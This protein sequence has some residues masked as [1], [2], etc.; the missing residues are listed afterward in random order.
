MKE[1]CPDGNIMMATNKGLLKYD[2]DKGVVKKYTVLDGLAD[3]D[4]RTLVR[5]RNGG[6][7][8]GTLNGLSFLPKDKE[9]IQSYSASL[10]LTEKSYV[11]SCPIRN[12]GTL[13]MGGFEGLTFFNSDSIS[14][15][16]F[17][18]NLKISGMYIN[19]KRITAATVGDKSVP[20]IEGDEIF[21]KA[22]HLSWKDRSLA[23]RL[24]TLDFRNTSR[25]RYEWQL[26]GDG[27]VWNSTA[28]GDNFVYLPSLDPGNYVLRLRGWEDNVCSDVSELMLNI[29]KPWYQ[30][31]T[32]KV[33]YVLIGLF[34]LGLLYKVIKSKREEELNEAKIKFFMDISHE[35]RSPITL[36]LSPVDSLLKQPQT[37]Q[38]TA[39]LLTVRRNAQRVLNLADQMLDIRKIEKGK[40]RLV[41][42]PTDLCGFI[43]ELVEMFRPQA[44]DK[45]LKIEFRSSEQSLMAPV[46]RNNLDK[47]LVNLISNAVKYTPSGGEIV[48]DLSR[49]VD[50]SERECY[51]IKVIDTGIGLDNKLI[52]H[53]FER[54]YRGREHHQQNT[55]GFG[56]GLDLCTRLVELHGGEI[57]G[58]NR[59]DGVKG[60]VFT[61]ILPI[62]PA[63]S[64][65]KQAPN[66]IDTPASEGG[67]SRLPFFNPAMPVK[68]HEASKSGRSSTRY[69]VMVVDDDTELRE[70]IKANLGN[71][72]KV[73]TFSSGE[74]AMKELA[75]KVPDII[76]TDIRMDGMDGFELLKRV[77]GNIST[78]HVPVILF[79]SINE[80]TERT[81]GWKSG[82][83]G[84]IAKPFSI[85]ELAGMING[86]L[87]TRQKLKGKFSGNQDTHE[88]IVMPKVKGMNQELMNSVDRYITENLSETELNV[89]NLSEYVGLSRSQLNR[90]L[91]EIVGISPSDYIRNI[92]LQKACELLRTTDIDISQV[93]Y[94]LGF[95]AQSHFSTLFKRFTGMTPSEYRANEK[96]EGNQD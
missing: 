87:S 92:K 34:I 47:I 59:E 51:E 95:T 26:S 89:D 76:V 9:S 48:V 11:F 96:R 82:A 37:P 24:S 83:D 10:G 23:L 4:V 46:D 18:G 19:G 2:T 70:Y 8:I 31:D 50:S 93:A 78:H 25:V 69:N 84:Y 1:P 77:K 72:Y 21:P 75:D 38:T 94:A 62:L 6:L 39:Q 7:W 65:T 36:L 35:I 85:D 53:L 52:K 68:P 17:G 27:D 30:A 33:V 66:I 90:R 58:K 15:M 61:V 3:N 86:L 20:I 79:S 22:L 81:R 43:R 67:L 73:K 12:Q 55:P 64:D 74:E 71:G 41:Y 49:T 32:A 13:V 91:K 28:L 5:D 40:M 16:S 57:S 54:F 63:G 88:R 42:T 60:S 44:S 14:P 29:S 56:I 45:G 80:A